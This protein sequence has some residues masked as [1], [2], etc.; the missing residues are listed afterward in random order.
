MTEL[1]DCFRTLE[2]YERFA[3]DH[4][5]LLFNRWRA[6]Q[7]ITHLTRTPGR[8]SGWSNLADGVTEFLFQPGPNGEPPVL[9]EQLV[10]KKTKMSARLRFGFEVLCQ[11]STDH[12]ISDVYLT[13]QISPGYNW[14]AGQFAGAVGSE[15]FD[16][17][18]QEQMAKK[19]ASFGP[20]GAVLRHEDIMA[21]SFADQ[22]FDAV[23]SYDVLEH[24]PDYQ[25]ALSEFARV[26]RPGGHLILTAPFKWDQHQ[27][28]IR[29]TQNPDG[30]INHILEPEYHGDPVRSEGVLCFQTFGWDVLDS[31]RE[32][33]FADAV[34]ALP[35]DFS[36]GFMGHLW[37][38]VARR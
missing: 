2:G 10:C 23:V 38:L 33:G 9:R 3:S 13:E 30:S 12:D 16:D 32:A 25:A 17:S 24:V 15:Y 4:S 21:L 35:W 5:D 28:L 19:L 31:V 11:L 37:T 1:A 22:S 36:R 18:Q 8:L 29:A 26:L 20:E 6:E 34:Y 14:L 7:T 27:T